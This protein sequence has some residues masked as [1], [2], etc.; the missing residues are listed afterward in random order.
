MHLAITTCTP[1][2]AFAA[3][4]YTSAVRSLLTGL[5]GGAGIQLRAAVNWPC[6]YVS[7][8]WISEDE[9]AELFDQV[10]PESTLID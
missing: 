9:T 10:P 6:L 3:S 7:A 5:Q 4:T 8:F 2:L 1:C